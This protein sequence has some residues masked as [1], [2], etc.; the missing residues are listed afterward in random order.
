MHTARQPAGS[1]PTLEQVRALWPSVVDHV[2]SRSRVVWMVVSASV[3]LSVEGGTVVAAHSD[4]GAV[5]HFG[6]TAGPGVVAEAMLD[7][8]RSE[9]VFEL[10][11]DPAR[12][13]SHPRRGTG[14]G[15]PANAGVSP[16]PATA[17]AVQP[18]DDEVL[19]ESEDVAGDDALS[20][21]A[22][23]QAAL[24]AETIEVIEE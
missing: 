7:V 5:A 22:L 9:L 2:K 21:I 23:V 18:S 12:S 6:R 16:A 8:L 1:G 24:G 11:H 17:P 14:G 15:A 4:A 19:A 3:P 10:V 13:G 20:G